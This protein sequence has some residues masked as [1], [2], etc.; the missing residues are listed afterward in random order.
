MSGCYKG[1]GLGREL[2]EHC[3]E[4]ARE[5]HGV[6][7]VAG[8]SPYLTDTRFYLHQGFEVV[9]STETGYDLVC[10]RG[11]PEAPL[12]RFAENARCGTVPEDQGV[13]FEYVSQC[14]F[15]PGCL[16]GLS[17]VARGLGLEAT[18]REL[19]REDAQNAASPFDTF[20]A[21][22]HG[23][24]VTHELMSEEKFRLLLERELEQ[25]G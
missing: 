23:R 14:P 1:H 19:T 17:A 3:L 7:S 5:Y 2:L 11:D 8:R 22:F 25:V 16:R 24:L 13:H 18:E 9:A 4:D 12:P 15:V 21:F 6:V 10:Y 20:G